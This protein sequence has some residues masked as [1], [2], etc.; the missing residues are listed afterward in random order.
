MENNKNK[1]RISQ[2]MLFIIFFGIVSLFSDMTHEGASSIR[3]AYFTILGASAGAIGFVSGL[4]ELIGYSMRYVFG[5]IADKRKNYWFMTIFGYVI[6][7][8]AVPALALVGENGWIAAAILLIIQR[9][10]KAI[11]KPAKDTIMSFAASQEGVGKS[12]GIQ[13]MLDQ[14]GAFLG[15]VLLYLVMLFKTT[16]TTFEIY[17]TCFAV[18]AIP[19]AITIIML[20]I[21]R[22]KFPNPENFEPEAKEFVP[23]EM[24]KSFKYYIMG[25]SLFAFGFI[26]YS[27]V[28]MHIS[29]NFTSIAGG[30]AETSSIINSGTIP[31]LYAGAMLVDAVAALIFGYMYD[32]KG[33]KVLVLSTIISAPF[34][35]FVFL[36]KSVP[37]VIF[38]VVLWG[39]GM[40]AQESILKAAVTTMVPKSSRATGYGIFECSFGIFWFLGSWLL[41][42]LYDVSVPVMV[43]VSVVAQIAAIPM[44]LKSTKLR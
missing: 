26:D 32:K 40:G 1:K 8:L 27:L 14:I 11:K 43:V 38:G 10:G 18:L 5:R 17:S 16:G 15:P 31:L 4:G 21:T 44:Y 7:V 30:L 6:D 37:M 3:G 24:K 29:R 34:S 39:I 19:G 33:V 23:F 13:E 25:I 12:F 36:G 2:A 42:V 20:L 28:I 9:M 35:A 22:K 41:G